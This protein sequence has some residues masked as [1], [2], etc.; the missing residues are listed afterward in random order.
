MNKYKLIM[1]SEVIIDDNK[2]NFKCSSVND[3]E[4]YS[5]EF[6]HLLPRSFFPGTKIHIYE[7]RCPDCNLEAS[8]CEC[9]FDW[10]ENKYAL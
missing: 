5:L 3:R 2:P 9:G 6:I 7:P 4:S 1:W 8:L 10:V